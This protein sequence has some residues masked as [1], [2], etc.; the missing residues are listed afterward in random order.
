MRKVLSRSQ[1]TVTIHA[2]SASKSIPSANIHENGKFNFNGKL[3]EMLK[4]RSFEISFTPDGKN[5]MLFES[6]DAANAV[7]FPKSGSCKLPEAAAHLRKNKIP[8]PANYS[9]WYNEEGEFWQGDYTGNPIPSA[10]W[11]ST[12]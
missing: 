10:K 6:E 9:V 5:F 3:N 1:F 8:L 4:S 11:S 7:R 12:K 2:S